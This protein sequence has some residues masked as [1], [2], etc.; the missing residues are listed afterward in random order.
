MKRI[1]LI[2]LTF[3]LFAAYAAAQPEAPNGRQKVRPVT[4]PIS[5]FTKQEIKSGLA[6]EIV[7]IEMLKVSEDKED[8]TIL[9]LRSVSDSPLSVAILIQEEVNGDVNLQLQSVRDFITGMPQGTRVM[10][11]YIRG[12][13]LLTLAKFTTDHDKAAKSVRIVPGGSTGGG[14]GAYDGIDEAI[15]KFQS[16]PGGRRAIFLI[17][18]GFD[19]LQGT[20]PASIANSLP[21]DRVI[22]KA[23]KNSVA[24]YSIY[25]PTSATSDSHTLASA[26]QAALQRVADETGGKAYFQGFGAPVS[27][28][29]FFRDLNMT[30]GRQFAL[31]YL[32]THMK[33]G[34]HKV[35]VT[36]TNPDI[37]IGHPK[38]YYYR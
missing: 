12:G 26:G 32:S 2:A 10:V 25:I 15:G 5:I 14:T 6:N 24:I 1:W 4:I 22:S 19:S 33:K 30:L 34:Y 36:S 27:L 18:D 17:S 31:T 38:G 7:E 13:N 23:Q 35:E 8:Q 3:T 37:K 20:S 21:V 29:P 28:T 9:S 11:G 16:L